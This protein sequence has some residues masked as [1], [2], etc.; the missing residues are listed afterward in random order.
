MEITGEEVACFFLKAS[1]KGYASGKKAAP[2]AVTI[3]PGFRGYYY[4]EGSWKY[5][6]AY[7][8]GEEGKS[9]GFTTITYQNIQVFWMSYGGEVKKLVMDV[10]L[11]SKI[12]SDDVTDF[13]KEALMDNYRRWESEGSR[14]FIGG[15]G[16]LVYV[17]K[18]LRYR[19]EL[20][21]PAVIG[22]I[23]HFTGTERI[24]FEAPEEVKVF[25]HNYQGGLL[26][27]LP[28]RR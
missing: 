12:T 3:L 28:K 8:V 1:L 5:L 15:R 16:R 19:N 25:Y 9:W 20:H 18:P 11:R 23:D 24:F 7:T 21:V 10:L 13:L 4:Q 14:A 22:T 27:K 17:K 6:D 26:V 2:F